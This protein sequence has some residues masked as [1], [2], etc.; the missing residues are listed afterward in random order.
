M[1]T[2]SDKSEPKLRQSSGPSTVNGDSPLTIFLGEDEGVCS[3]MTDIGVSPLSSGSG[4]S[5]AEGLKNQL[6]DV[7]S[8]TLQLWTLSWKYFSVR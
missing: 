2:S 7:A 5:V 3:P 6:S 8:P 1:S 4:E